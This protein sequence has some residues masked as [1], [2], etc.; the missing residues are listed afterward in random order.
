MK[1]TESLL[2]ETPLARE[3]IPEL[4][5]FDRASADLDITRAAVFAELGD[6]LAVAME[7]TLDAGRGYLDTKRIP[8][9]RTLR[10]L[11]PERRGECLLQL[12]STISGLHAR[13]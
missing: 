8:A 10:E 4:V 2:L 6:P 11:S 7:A 9:F 3:D 5:E 12:I 13:A 1:L